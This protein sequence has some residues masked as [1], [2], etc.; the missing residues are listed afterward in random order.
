LKK[1]KQKTFEFLNAL[2]GANETQETKVFWFFFFK[3]EHLP[4]LVT[5]LDDRLVAQQFAADIVTPKW[6]GA[7]EQP[8]LL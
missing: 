6:W 4:F 5:Y 1:K 2:A 3:K 7:E 8:M